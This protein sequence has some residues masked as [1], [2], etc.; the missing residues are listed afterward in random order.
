M[1]KVGL[2]ACNAC[3]HLERRTQIVRT[4]MVDRAHDFVETKLDPELRRLMND[5]KQDFV[6]LGAEGTLTIEQFRELEIVPIG[7]RLAKVPVHALAREINGRRRLAAL[8]MFVG[9]HE[10]NS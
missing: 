5:K 9:S 8:H 10:R 4:D 3:H 2:H 7:H 1:N 6:V